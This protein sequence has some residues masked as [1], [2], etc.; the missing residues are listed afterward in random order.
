M[1]AAPLGP[2]RSDAGSHYF[3]FE[4]KMISISAADGRLRPCCF[5]FLFLSVGV[6]AFVGEGRGK[7]K[8]NRKS[9]GRKK[10]SVCGWHLRISGEKEKKKKNVIQTK[11]QEMKFS[12]Q[13]CLCVICQGYSR[14][15]QNITKRNPV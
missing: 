9:E 12:S 5:S 10:G 3:F 14:L 2:L 4:C 6:S 13:G 7:R 11:Q 1:V 8:K 15:F